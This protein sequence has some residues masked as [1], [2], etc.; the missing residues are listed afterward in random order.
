MDPTTILSRIRQGLDLVQQLEPLASLAGPGAAGIANIVAGLSEIAE[1]AIQNIETG[2]IA[3]NGQQ[4]DELKA[5]LQEL[6]QHN[7][8]L[9]DNIRRG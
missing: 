1:G 3:A 9:T 7:D 6:R 5:L 2:M 8:R 4:Q